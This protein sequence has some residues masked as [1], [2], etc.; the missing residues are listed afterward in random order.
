[1]NSEEAITFCFPETAFTTVTAYQNQ[2]VSLKKEWGTIDRGIGS[3]EVLI[4][5]FLDEL[6]R[7]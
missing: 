4:Y 1:M 7:D 3:V 6:V 2:Q 5:S